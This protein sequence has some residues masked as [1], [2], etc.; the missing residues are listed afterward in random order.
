MI[1]LTKRSLV[2]SSLT[3]AI[4]TQIASAVSANAQIANP[5]HTLVIHNR[6][7][8]SL[9]VKPGEQ[10]LVKNDDLVDHSVS[11]AGLGPEN[12]I[13]GKSYLVFT[14]PVTPG[15]YKL[16]CDSLVSPKRVLRVVE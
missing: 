8:T 14:A 5:P 6:H 7:F 1:H 4:V 10:F 15:K 9:A 12:L 11:I 2:L 3:F 13:H 16:A